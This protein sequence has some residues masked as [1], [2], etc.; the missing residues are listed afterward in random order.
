MIA[1]LNVLNLQ[2]LANV[3]LSIF[4]FSNLLSF[5]IEATQ[6]SIRA[7][8]YPPLTKTSKFLGGFKKTLPVPS[9]SD[10][11]ISGK[12]S[13]DDDSDYRNAAVSLSFFTPIIAILA[14]LV[15][16]FNF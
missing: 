5:D 8:S 16:K 11:G 12:S 7:L 13:G 2:L 10:D 3:S 9:M 1:N 14:G 6:T 15:M 4:S